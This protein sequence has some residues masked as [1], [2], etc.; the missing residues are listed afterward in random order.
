MTAGYNLSD[1]VVRW[2]NFM[3]LG[4][5]ILRRMDSPTFGGLAIDLPQLDE[6]QSLGGVQVPLIWI[7]FAS[8]VP[9][10]ISHCC[11][12]PFV[13]CQYIGCVFIG[14]PHFSRPLWS[15]GHVCARDTRTSS[16]ALPQAPST[17][18]VYF[19]LS[20]KGLG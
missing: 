10:C 9:F 19:L 20:S 16:S 7:Q 17:L 4:C 1:S 13:S 12:P 18:T 6:V 2:N 3:V 8:S 5:G 11:L 15:V 14:T